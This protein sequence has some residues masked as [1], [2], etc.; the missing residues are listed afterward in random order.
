MLSAFAQLGALRLNAKRGVITLASNSKEY[1]IAE[2]SQ[3]LSLQQDNDAQDK[4]WHG[5]GAF[6]CE[7]MFLEVPDILGILGNVGRLILKF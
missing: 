5:I 1:I 2:S 6:D 7:Y 4:L 3:S